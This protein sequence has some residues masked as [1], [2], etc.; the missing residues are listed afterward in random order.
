LSAAS[1]EERRRRRRRRRGKN[2]INGSTK[3]PEVGG[4]TEPHHTTKVNAK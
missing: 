1:T 2:R 4:V 3:Q